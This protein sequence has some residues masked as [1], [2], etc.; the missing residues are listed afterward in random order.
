LHSL[1]SEEISA[2]VEEGEDFEGENGISFVRA[3]FFGSLMTMG[4]VL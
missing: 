2:E 1:K 3:R 4:W